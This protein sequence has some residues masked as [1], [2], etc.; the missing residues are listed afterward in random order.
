MKPRVRYRDS[1]TGRFVSK[2][3][4]VKHPSTTYGHRVKPAPKKGRAA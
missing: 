3:Y 2:A 1:V 4:A